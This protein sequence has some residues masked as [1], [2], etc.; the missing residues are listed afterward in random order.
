MSD[1]GDPLLDAYIDAAER[2]STDNHRLMVILSDLIKELR[3]IEMYADR[4]DPMVIMREAIARAESRL[5]C[6]YRQNA[7]VG[8]CARE[9]HVGRKKASV[10]TPT[11]GDR[12]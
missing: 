4:M 5:R 8:L 1:E 9:R 10:S 3:G 2:L 12:G 7:H 11:G 6:P